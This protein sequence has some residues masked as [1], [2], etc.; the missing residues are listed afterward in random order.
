MLNH[1][2]FK[3]I[4]R[5]A[6]GPRNYTAL[7]RAA[8][9]YECPFAAVSR[10]FSGGGHYPCSVR[11]RTPTGPQSVTLFGGQD[12]I[13]V[14]EIFCRQ[15]YRCPSPP[16]VVVDIGANI[17]V[18]ALYFL[19]RSSSVYCEL[20]EPDPRNLP[21]LSHNLRGYRER[22]TLHEMA[23]ADREGV[24]SFAREPTGRY[25]TLETDSWVW[26]NPAGIETDRISVRVAHVNTVLDRAIS[27]HGAVDL[28]K[29]DTEGSEL[30][31]LLAIEPALRASVRHIVIEWAEE[32]IK[33]EGFSALRSCDTVM[34]TNEHF[35][36]S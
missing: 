4:A 25:G 31:T 33:L 18:S 13:T 12:A 16:R 30:A 15:D 34:F 22:F 3:L 21:K 27:R 10:Y 1:R 9:I 14:H 29:I 32:D 20:Y 28:L 17:G 2:S 24:L 26:H 35:G 23:V 7:A 5:S 8:W 36:S 19:T 6:V 11:V